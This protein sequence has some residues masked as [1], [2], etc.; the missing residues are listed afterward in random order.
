[1]ALVV[2]ILQYGSQRPDLQFHAGYWWPGDTKSQGIISHGIDL[3]LLEK[4]SSL[5]T[6]STEVSME[7]CINNIF[8]CFTC[9]SAFS[10]FSGLVLRANVASCMGTGIFFI[11]WFLKQKV[12]PLSAK[13]FRGYLKHILTFHVIPLNWYDTGGWNPSSRQGPT[14]STQSIPGD[15]RSQDISSYDIDLVKLR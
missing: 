2:E 1:M 7:Q 15:A 13:F 5:R 9:C 14:H 10:T 12:N 3:F 6:G 4:Y 11:L 8:G